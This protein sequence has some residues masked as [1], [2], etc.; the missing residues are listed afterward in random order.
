LFVRARFLDFN[1]KTACRS[2]PGARHDLRTREAPAQT[3][4]AGPGAPYEAFEKLK[5]APPPKALRKPR[6]RPLPA[7]PRAIGI[8][9]RPQAALRDMLTTLARRAPMTRDPLP[10][11]VQG[12]GAGGWWRA[13]SQRR[14]RAVNATC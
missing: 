6:K 4:P 7:F 13:R 1:P 11:Q 12:E 5:A 2:S 14:T 10:A 9:P 8:G 3:R